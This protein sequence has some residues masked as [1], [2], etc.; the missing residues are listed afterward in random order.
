MSL[1]FA[2]VPIQEQPVHTV[3]GTGQESLCSHPV[4]F[5]TSPQK[6]NDASAMSLRVPYDYLKSLLSFLC[7][8]DYLKSCSVFTISM[9]CQY[10]DHAIYLRCVYRLANFQNLSMCGVNKIEEVTMPVNL[11]DDGKVSLLWPH[12]KGELDIINSSEG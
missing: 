4:I 10:G 9:Q 6:S 8:N 5:M 7:P 11:N 1:L 3:Y 2:N 12:G